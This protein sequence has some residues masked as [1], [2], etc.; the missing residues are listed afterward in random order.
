[1]KNNDVFAQRSPD[2]VFSGTAVILKILK[3]TWGVN[4]WISVNGC[5]CLWTSDRTGKWSTG[6]DPTLIWRL[7]GLAAAF[8]AT[9]KFIM[10]L[11]KERKNRVVFLWFKRRKKNLQAPENRRELFHLLSLNP[12]QGRGRETGSE[13]GRKGGRE[14]G[15]WRFP[16]VIRQWPGSSTHAH[17]HTC[18]QFNLSTYPSPSP[19]THGE[20]SDCIQSDHQLPPH[21]DPP[22]LELETTDDC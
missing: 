21:S 1:M 13:V 4:M 19:H 10:Q 11:K 5:C 22:P 8:S 20:Q 17:I 18:H 2:C 16:A 15:L 9:V 12:F 6:C 14:G 7:L 3:L